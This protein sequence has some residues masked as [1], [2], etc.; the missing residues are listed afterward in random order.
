MLTTK[1]E[2]NK[3]TANNL[4]ESILLPFPLSEMT[5]RSALRVL[6]RAPRPEMPNGFLH[7]LTILPEAHRYSNRRS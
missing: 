3:A 4:I 7:L 6:I 2:T 1:P 5:L